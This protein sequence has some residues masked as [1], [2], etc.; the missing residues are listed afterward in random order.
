VQQLLQGNW[1]LSEVQAL[2]GSAINW[3]KEWQFLVGTIMILL[4]GTMMV[5]AINRQTRRLDLE[6]A[7]GRRRL[8]KALRVTMPDDLDAIRSYAGRS[9]AVARQAVLLMEKEEKSQVDSV[10]AR[11]KRLRCPTIPGN[12]LANIKDLIVSLDHNGA[13]KLAELVACYYVQRHRLT[14]ALQAL[15]TTPIGTGT[16]KSMNFNP[17]FKSTLELYLRAMNM[18]PFARGETETIP[19]TYD[20]HEI[21]HGMQAL[22][23][24]DVMSPEAREHCLRF[25][26]ES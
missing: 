15:E 5:R 10:E 12:V 24:N 4:A 6:A 16:S 7:E 2:F 11:K 9:A 18:L 3:L 26:R 22:N 13:D 1:W 25:Y 21:L 20:D 17:V 8:V 14:S 19:E 23:I